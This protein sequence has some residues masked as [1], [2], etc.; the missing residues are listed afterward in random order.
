MPK[1]GTSTLCMIGIRINSMRLHT[2]TG[3]KWYRRCV[4]SESVQKRLKHLFLILHI[5]HNA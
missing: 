3:F 1:M 4:L 5:I 2:S